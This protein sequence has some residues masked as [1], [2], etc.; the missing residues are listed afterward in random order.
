MIFG[1][2]IGAVLRAQDGPAQIQTP[3]SQFL[4]LIDLE[5][6]P[7]KQLVLMDLFVKQ[8]PKYNAMAAVY[9]DMQA[10][11]VK[12]GS[13]DLALE[14]GDKLLQVD[15]DDIDAIRLN[16]EAA[17]GKNDQSLAKKWSDRL[18]QLTQEPNGTISASSSISTPYV[19]GAGMAG[20]SPKDPKELG[21]KT[22][23]A[24]QEAALFNAALEAAA[25][26]ARIA[27]LDEF[28]QKFPQSV[29]LNKVNYLY[30]LAYRDMKDE[31][32]AM[33]MAEQ[34]LSKDRT[35]EDLLYYVAENLFKQKRELAKVVSYS[36]DILSLVKRPKPDSR[37]EDEWNRQLNLLTTQAHWM[38][39]MAEI[40]RENF[41]QANLELRAALSMGSAADSI[42]PA[43]LTN[44]GWANY[45]IKNIPDA[46]KFY[47]DCAAIPSPYQ[48][49][50]ED[51][52]KGIRSE[53]GLAE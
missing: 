8:F 42:R 50:A 29:H 20:E 30:Y 17:K 52:V 24:R 13:W 9:A 44:L 12:V 53:Y 23:R 25:P 46:I 3:E 16:L 40:Y 7:A 32:K 39:G 49:A 47:K 27:A 34:I 2:I 41:P 45:K 37:P 18:E 33:S 15:Q 22:A 1:G 48:K 51:S 14:I 5:S 4:E 26:P 28:C 11:Y 35:H 36:Q 38:I 10:D 43:L 31:Q 21:V 6:D 19:E